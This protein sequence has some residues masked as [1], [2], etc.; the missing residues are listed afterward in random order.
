[1]ATSTPDMVFPSTATI[2][3]HKLGIVGAAAFDVQAVCSGFVYALTVAD[4]M[5]KTGSARC[6]GSGAE[7]FSR[8]L[9]FDDRTTCVLFGDG[10]GAVVFK[11]LTPQ[12]CLRLVARRR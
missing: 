1:M 3:E 10:A 9:D 12:V 7:V 11:P 2:V 6:L 4:A 8:I 5:I